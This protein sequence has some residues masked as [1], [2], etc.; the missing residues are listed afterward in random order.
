MITDG[1]KQHFNHNALVPHNVNISLQHAAVRLL[2]FLAQFLRFF[3]IFAFISPSWS[4]GQLKR[5]HH[6][7]SVQ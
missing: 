7:T 4:R 2:L 3:W 1:K 5:I 6:R